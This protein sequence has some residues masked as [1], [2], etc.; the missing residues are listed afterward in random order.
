MSDFET[1]PEVVGWVP[2]DLQDP[3]TFQFTDLGGGRPAAYD[4]QVEG[5]VP[6][7]GH[8]RRYIPTG[9]NFEPIQYEPDNL[10][11]TATLGAAFE[12]FGPGFR[13]D[14]GKEAPIQRVITDRFGE[15]FDTHALVRV[16][17]TETGMELLRNSGYL[18]Q[19]EDVRYPVQQLDSGQVEMPFW[20]AA[21]VFGG[22][23]MREE[24][25]GNEIEIF[26]GR[27]VTPNGQSLDSNNPG[28]TQ[29]IHPIPDSPFLQVTAEY[30]P[31]LPP[32]THQHTI[33]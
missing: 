3:V 4:Q 22:N 6:L 29:F 18:D 8:L 9:R 17:P 20:Q 25:F 1:G 7:N 12:T 26:D 14:I 21:N 28:A 15:E 24:P 11:G 10:V 19:A 5:R 16:T 13:P 32:G 33:W 23:A 27:P 30:Y 31:G 2:Y